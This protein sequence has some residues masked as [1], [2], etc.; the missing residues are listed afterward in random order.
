MKLPRGYNWI[1]V[2]AAALYGLTTP[3]GIAVGLGLRSSYNPES[4]TAAIVS[5]ILDALSAGILIYTG[6]VEVC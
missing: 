1:P 6:L 4:T 2:V 5:G 3:L